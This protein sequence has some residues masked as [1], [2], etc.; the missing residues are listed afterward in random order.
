MW[1]RVQGM[2]SSLLLTLRSAQED[3]YNNHTGLS[4]PH[5]LHDPQQLAGKVGPSQ[6]H[7]VY[8]EGGRDFC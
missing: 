1:F 7:F 5:R 3:T 4:R 6:R 2:G 8:S